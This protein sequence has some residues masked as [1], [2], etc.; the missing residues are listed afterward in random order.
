MPADEPQ[1][2][3]LADAIAA[4]LGSDGRCP[5]CGALML[6]G[7]QPCRVREW[8]GGDTRAR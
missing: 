6:V 7:W 1:S 5:N 3:S 8:T 4:H 2:D